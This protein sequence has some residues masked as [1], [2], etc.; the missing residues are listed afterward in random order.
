MFEINRT[1]VLKLLQNNLLKGNITDNYFA[2]DI[3]LHN[4]HK[5]FVYHQVFF[6]R[7]YGRGLLAR[8]KIVFFKRL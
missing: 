3:K 6:K 7:L 2:H 5:V 4:L 1:H 8:Q